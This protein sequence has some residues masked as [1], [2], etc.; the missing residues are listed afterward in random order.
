MTDRD[1]AAALIVAMARHL[2]ERS[3]SPGSSGNLSVRLAHTVLVTPTGSSFS[4]VTA[5]ELSEVDHSGALV[6]GAAPTKELALHLGAYSVDR[7]INAVVHL[8][9]PA[10]TAISCLPPRDGLADLPAYTPYRVMSLGRVP[11]V[12]YV[13]PGDRRLGD[14]VRAQLEAGHRALLL[15]HHGSVLAAGSLHRAVDLAEE[16]EAS[17]QLAL[18]LV[19]RGAAELSAEQQAEL[20]G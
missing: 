11:L 19:G 16:L 20:Q 1:D 18:A 14:G 7:A 4:R 10:A 17:A 3:L 12:E 15:A 9:S 8:H 13:R 5:D 2:S 6:A